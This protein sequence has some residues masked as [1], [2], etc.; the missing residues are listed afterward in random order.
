MRKKPRKLRMPISHTAFSQRSVFEVV[1]DGRHDGKQI[2]VLRLNV[3]V[4]TLLE[5]NGP[6]VVTGV[7]IVYRDVELV[8]PSPIV[9]LTQFASE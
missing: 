5:S 9:E 1:R 4:F 2:H 6:S 7:C 8:L 3:A